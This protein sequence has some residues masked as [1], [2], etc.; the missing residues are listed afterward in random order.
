MAPSLPRLPRPATIPGSGRRACMAS[1]S[2]LRFLAGSSLDRSGGSGAARRFVYR[3]RCI[4]FVVA[5]LTVPPSVTGVLL[6]KD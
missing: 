1:F 2:A 6:R 3:Y 5:W 4:R